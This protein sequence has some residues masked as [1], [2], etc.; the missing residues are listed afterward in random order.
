MSLSK[1]AEK[2]TDKKDTKD[3]K[4]R[5]VLSRT[6]HQIKVTAMIIHELRNNRILP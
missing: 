5:D 6:I 4:K 3:E 1:K 2:R